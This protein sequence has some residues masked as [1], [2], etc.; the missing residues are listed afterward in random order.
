MKKI[1][2]YLIGLVFFGGL[3]SF[4]TPAKAGPGITIT[5]NPAGA[6]G[7]VGDKITITVNITE[8]PANANRVVLY[9]SDAVAPNDPNA[10]TPYIKDWWDP[11]AAGQNQTHTYTWDTQAAGSS[12]G[13]HY[14][15]VHILNTNT[16]D[17]VQ[18]VKILLENHLAYY[19]NA[20]SEPTPT[21][22]GGTISP[23]PTNTASSGSFN[24][25]NL[26]TFVFSI[27]NVKD[28]K[29]LIAIVI[30]YMLSF[31]GLLAVVALLYSGVMYITAG[32]DP[33]KA[34]LAKKNILWAII[35]I[36]I[37]LLSVTIVNFVINIL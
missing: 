10:A 7:K 2:L 23:S 21:P 29:S 25:G 33:A 11:P 6:G 24:L 4:A 19:L 30:N 36:V 8:S 12:P 35:G 22:S 26:G 27:K 15:T 28:T 16:G 20:A 9:I 31:M 32:A 3:I 1:F 34:E 13:Y 14:I 17:V 5:A 37:V 18:P